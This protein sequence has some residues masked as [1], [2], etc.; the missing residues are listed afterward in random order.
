[1]DSLAIIACFIIVQGT[2]YCISCCDCLEL[3]HGISRHTVKSNITKLVTTVARL[4][5]FPFQLCLLITTILPFFRIQVWILNMSDQI[6]QLISIMAAC[7]VYFSV[8][9]THNLVC[10]LHYNWFIRVLTSNFLF[11]LCA[12]STSVTSRFKFSI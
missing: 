11:Q 6:L 7:S 5:R 2:G 4:V 10:S 1:M 9:D 3:A 8:L 12:S